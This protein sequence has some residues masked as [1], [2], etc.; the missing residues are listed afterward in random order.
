MQWKYKQAGL[1]GHPRF[2]AWRTITGWGDAAARA[3]RKRSGRT[4]VPGASEFVL[5]LDCVVN[6]I[7]ED[8]HVQ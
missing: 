7:D 4:K 1:R 5:R 8:Y 6:I 2:S 3:D